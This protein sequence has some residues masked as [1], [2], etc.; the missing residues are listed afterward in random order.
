MIM[1]DKNKFIVFLGLP[2]SGKG[3]QSKILTEKFDN[4]KSLSSGDL[5]RKILKDKADN[6][7]LHNKLHEV[8]SSGLL[9]DDEMIF[10][11]VKNEICS[12]FRNSSL[13][14][15][16]EVYNFILDG[17]PRTIKQCEMLDD[18]LK[19]AEIGVISLV[20]IFDLKKR[21]AVK[22]LLDRLICKDCGNIQSVFGLKK[23]DVKD[24]QCK[25]C[26]GELIK[27]KDD[28]I[29]AIRKRLKNDKKII[30][31]LL[32]FYQNKGVKCIKLNAALKISV[33]HEKIK[34]IIDLL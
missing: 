11:I 18:F 24:L 19:K 32:K 20:I 17:F 7:E 14:Q 16:E 28:H 30:D 26:L 33:L 13:P 15:I 31:F 1:N 3:T 10:K 8:V 2:G 25:K 12:W 34:N 6:S 23:L 22:R 27:R 21:L 29:V 9:V 4:F 5:I